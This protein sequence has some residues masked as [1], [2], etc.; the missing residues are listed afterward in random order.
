MTKHILQLLALFTLSL[1]PWVAT[2]EDSS[3]IRLNLQSTGADTNA[4]GTL[5]AT[6]RSRG[7]TLSLSLANLTPGAPYTVVVGV[8]PE[9][10]FNADSRGRARLS[11]GTLSRRGVYPLDFDPRG[12]TLAVQE[13][14]T[15]ILQAVVSGFGEPEKSAVSERVELRLVGSQGR[16]VAQYLLLS[17]GRRTF[18][19]QLTGVSGSNWVLYVDGLRRGDFANRGTTGRLGF[20]STPRNTNTLLL[21]FDPRGKVLDIARETNLVFS[22][23]MAA[24]ATNVSFAAP[25]AQVAFIPSTGVDPDG[26]ARAKLKVDEKARQKFSVE[27]EDVPVGT[28]ELLA[29][30]VLTANVQV[31]TNLTGTEGEV[32]F[33]SREDN[34]DE[35]PLTFDPTNTVFTVQRAGTVYFTGA[36]VLPGSGTNTNSGPAFLTEALSSTGLDGDAHGEAKFEV[37]DRGRQKFSVEIED[38]AEGSY[39]LWVGGVQRATFAAQT[40]LGKVTGEIEFEAGDDD[41]DELPLNFDPRGQL[42]EVRGTAGTY[43]SHVFG[44]G[45]ATNSPGL[46]TPLEIVLPLFNAGAPVNATARMEYQ[47]D[48]DGGESFE[49]ELEDLAVGNYELWVGATQRAV[50]A[51]VATTGGT[52][53]QVEFDDTPKAGESLLN[54][55]PRGEIITVVGS[56]GVLFQRVLP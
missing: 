25:R 17:T 55:N 36:L 39:A 3:S 45:G 47:R 38:V 29:D 5:Q 35:L 49:V 4:V 22:G 37:D 2:A 53:G 11:F 26:T 8:T 51:V 42:I 24:Q 31:I 34:G 40:I 13:N 14:G 43:F 27:L 16:A 20:D 9:A 7:S 6:F 41:T 52:R 21:D 32:E 46:T 44:N 1:T 48:D 54:F 30:G 18:N 19:V 23:V 56:S 28:Y 12:Q 15:N 33:S 50:I 10:A